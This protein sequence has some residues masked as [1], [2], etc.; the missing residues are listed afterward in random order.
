MAAL[1]MMYGVV[2]GHGIWYPIN[3]LAVGFFPERSTVAQISVFHLQSL[4]IASVL[5]LLVSVLVGLLYGAMLPMFPRRPILLGGLFAPILWSGLL[6]SVLEAIDPV[7]NQ[8][9]HWL[10]FV[11][12]QIGF[13]VVAGIVVSKQ[14]RVKTWQYMPFAVRAGI[15]APGAMDEK[16]GENE[17]Q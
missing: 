13:G 11:I 5:H 9:I 10:W 1:A 6:H 12:S 16:G 14:S 15:E 2:S 17:Q 7:M 8:R 4:I 3:L